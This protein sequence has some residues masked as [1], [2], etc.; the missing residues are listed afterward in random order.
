LQLAEKFDLQEEKVRIHGA[1]TR[2]QQP[3]L[4]T[5]A[6]ELSLDQ[7]VI[8]IQDTPRIIM[9]MAANPSALRITWEFMK[10]NW[11]EFDRRYG[12]GGFAVMRLVS[13]TGAF[14][15]IEDLHDV[16]A[17]FDANPVPAATRTVEQSLERI[18]LNNKWLDLNVPTLSD[19][20]S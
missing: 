10:D 20:F 4:I 11:K 5:R 12:G 6:L 16:K 13:I 15:T 1:L 7:D 17:F 8:R 14:N 3:N 19:W 9:G 2:F 18:N